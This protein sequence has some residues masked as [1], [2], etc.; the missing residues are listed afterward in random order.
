MSPKWSWLTGIAT[1]LA[2][3]LSVVF[4]VATQSITQRDWIVIII[5]IL[6][7]GAATAFVATF[8]FHSESRKEKQTAEANV[9]SSMAD[10]MLQQEQKITTTMGL[11]PSRQTRLEELQ[12]EILEL[13]IA[14]FNSQGNAAVGMAQ[15][16]D[17]TNHGYIDMALENKTA[18]QSWIL[19]SEARTAELSRR[20][21]ELGRVEA[22]SDAE[23]KA[24]Q[25]QLRFIG[26]ENIRNELK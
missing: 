14:V 20:E 3:A 13:K 21:N 25:V 8:I 6:V 9:A 24:E 7:G 18:A 26:P 15:A 16:R 5:G 1:L 2:L 10:T 19:N 23:W 11:I 4:F 12:E 22:L 17:A